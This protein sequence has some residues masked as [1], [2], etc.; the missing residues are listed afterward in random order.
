MYLQYSVGLLL[1]FDINIMF[2]GPCLCHCLFVYL[3]LITFSLLI[4]IGNLAIE[5]IEIC[6]QRFGMLSRMY[7]KLGA[8]RHMFSV[9]IG[10]SQLFVFAHAI[11]ASLYRQSVSLFFLF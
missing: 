6:L 8:S 7:N 3:L 5:M 10:K 4:S 11:G 9:I 1:R 2:C